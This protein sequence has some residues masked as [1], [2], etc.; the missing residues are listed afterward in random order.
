MRFIY[1]ACFL[2]S[3]FSFGFISIASSQN[4]CS[5]TGSVYA[6]I[7]G[8]E[9]DPCISTSAAKDAVYVA[10]AKDDSTLILKL[11]LEGA[12]IWSRTLD[13][14]QGPEFPSNIL[15]DSDGMIAIAGIEGNTA[16]GGRVYTFRYDP[17]SHSVLWSKEYFT[18]Q[19]TY[20][21]SLLQKGIG[22][23]YVHCTNPFFL[24]ASHMDVDV[25]ELDKNTGDPAGALQR[26]YTFFGTET[27]Y[28]L[29]FDGQFL[30]GIGRYK[31]GGS[32]T[33]FRSTIVKLNANDG[34]PV[35]T[36]MGHVPSNMPA[37][38]YG[39][40]IVLDG[41]QIISAHFGDPDGNGFADNELYL[42]KSTK[43]GAIEWCNQYPL[44][45]DNLDCRELIVVPD[46]YIA[47]ASYHGPDEK[48]VVFK[49]DGDGAVQW[50]KTYHFPG[51]PQILDG[52]TGHERLL[53]IDDQLFFSVTGIT[54]SGNRDLII[55]R[56]DEEGNVD[57]PC[58]FSS[59]FP[60][61]HI[62]ILNPAFYDVFPDDELV[63]AQVFDLNAVSVP[64]PITSVCPKDS[65]F[66][67]IST[68]ICEGE[69]HEG[70]TDS[71]V[72]T[73]Y[74]ISVEGC[75]SVRTLL[76]TVNECISPCVSIGSLY[77]D[78][79]GNERGY[80]L[81]SAEGSN[82]FYAAGLKNDS[83][84]ICLLFANGLVEWSR[85]FDIVPNIEDHVS[86][87][88]V[89]S[90]GMLGIAGTTGDWPSGGSVFAFRYNPLLHEILW[91]KQYFNTG[92]NFSL[93]LI[94]NGVG[95]NYILSNNPHYAGDPFIDAELIEIDLISG[96]IVP[97]FSKKYHVGSAE[98]YVEIF[99]HSG[100][101]YGAGRFTDGVS[102]AG[103][104]NAI[105][106]INANDGTIIWSQS[107]HI[108]LNESARLYG[109]DLVV[110][111]GFIYS[112]SHGNPSGTSLT[113]VKLFVQKMTIDGLLIWVKQY[114]LPGNV[115][116]GYEI[117]KSSNGY[118]VYAHKRDD[119][120][121]LVLF[122]ID[123]N[124]NLL[125]SNQ[126]EF[127]GQINSISRHT[128]KSQLIQTGD[129]LVFTAF[130][131]TSGQEDI[132]I[133]RTDLNGNTNDPCI[134]F[135][136]ATV[137][138]VDISNAVLFNQMPVISTLTPAQSSPFSYVQSSSIQ[139]K[140]VCLITNTVHSFVTSAICTGETYEGYMEQGIYIDTFSAI[141]GCDS[142]RQLDLTVSD[143]VELNVFKS[144]CFGE[145]YE[146]YTVTGV[147]LDTLP[148][149]PGCDTVRI[150][151]LEVTQPLLTFLH[152]EICQGQSFLGYSTT[153]I[154]VDTFQNM[155]GCDSIRTLDLE[156]VFPEK[157]LD[158]TICFGEA[159]DGYN[160]S[161]LFHDTIPGNTNSCD[162][163]RHLNLV[164]LPVVQTEIDIT[165]CEGG[166]YLGYDTNGTFID[167]LQILS[168]CD[169]IRILNL[170]VA[171]T[172]V[173][174]EY[175]QICLGQDYM[176]LTEPGLYT[177]TLVSIWQCDSIYRL[178]LDV[179][180]L[181]MHE[182]VQL[183]S[184]SNYEN[185]S[186][187]GIYIDTLQGY[188]GGCDTIRTLTLT[189]NE[190]VHNS[191][192]QSICRGDQYEGYGLEGV[193]TDTLMTSSGCDSI[194]TI[195]LSVVEPDIVG[196]SLSLCDNHSLGFTQPGS[197]VDTLNSASGCDSIVTYTVS[198]YSVYVPN[199]FSPNGDGTNDVF[200]AT[201]FPDGILT[202]QYFAVFDRFGNMAYQTE[203]WPAL[204]DGTDKKGIQY[205]PG[206]FAFILLY[207][208]GTNSTIQTGSITLIR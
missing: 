17:D 23:N 53:A 192:Q 43:D 141:N 54:G 75:D 9:T 182:E 51:H 121:Y 103:M 64:S 44:P 86:T 120:G 68:T 139:I 116:V 56:T 168:G 29:Q 149:S 136:P 196:I 25:M 69:M 100:F 8:Y 150:L 188:Q 151:S 165:I 35:W 93:S 73:D 97:I 91:S 201:P 82:K 78:P 61:S 207:E 37:R 59:T 161:G 105:T 58:V 22:G 194:R 52:Y 50:S 206:V 157:N 76:L 130:E 125:W 1:P 148:A 123:A 101:I 142:I 115:D 199:V 167:T 21:H 28:D 27:L 122:K 3:F 180:P 72:Y 36:K 48:V 138:V 146:G 110:D 83:V 152:A 31:G 176:G 155:D 181:E 126:Y 84:L 14:M 127:L 111:G 98:E 200:E 13:I 55:V 39:V 177:D 32:M 7:S 90:D 80:S 66:T 173:F 109:R 162:T 179:V 204:W 166:N 172:L 87:I 57:L 70:Y 131:I 11:S 62:P 81:A 195:S 89:D 20:S 160:T 144:I 45:G 158:V 4:N 145:N 19:T 178:H 129:Q 197:Y 104:R 186:V 208:C 74:F 134:N 2:I 112:V 12:V 128:A 6:S 117:I 113:D 107:G 175:I 106:K 154:H 40:Q 133:V 140:E 24:S 184:G 92:N 183:C 169:S 102:A 38:L 94:Q 77:G 198:G 5:S 15:V 124:G 174:D 41:N 63:S 88:I 114:D 137:E 71:G 18:H 96:N 79:L 189:V 147:Y 205:N 99:H 191:F 47:L 60:L 170:T 153:G 132:I 135:M 42:Q 33:D 190:T 202:L 193:Y 16:T 26:R 49:I 187:S 65:L 34:I 95:G 67:N 159:Y 118:V 85:T 143:L 164:V 163:L 119:P 185:Y 171:D 156:V 46:G 10:A 203:N 108:P 30:Y